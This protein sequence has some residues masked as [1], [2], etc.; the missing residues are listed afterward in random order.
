M[1]YVLLA[2][3]ILLIVYPLYAI[4]QCLAVLGSL[5]NYGIG[6]FVGGLIL[7]FSGSIIL[8]LTL[9]SFKQKKQSQS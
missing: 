2:V 4:V 1:K 5:S 7:L 6:V 3:A 9:K 8:Y